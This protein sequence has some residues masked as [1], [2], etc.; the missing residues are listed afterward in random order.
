MTSVGLNGLLLEAP[1]SGTATYTRNLVP[2][3]AQAA[4]ELTFRLYS[5]G[6]ASPP[7]DVQGVRVPWPHMTVAGS[8][9][10]RL[11]KLSWEELALPA[12]SAMKGDTLLHSLYF[13]APFVSRGRLVVTVHDLVPLLMPGYHR[14]RQ[15]AVYARFM[16]G[17]VRRADAIVT[18]SEHSK[19]EIV[20]Q[21][22]IPEDRVHVT[23]EAADSRFR[24]QREPAEEERLR[25]RYSLPERFFLYLG[26]AERRKDI[27]TLVRAWSRIS[28]LMQT[29]GTSLVIVARFP[30]PDTLYP[31]IPG[32]IEA[33]GVAN[34]VLVRAVDESDKPALFRMATAFAFPSVYE[35][36]GLPPLEAMASGV[37]VLASNATSIP[38]VVGDAAVLIPPGE[39]DSWAEALGS[40]AESEALRESLSARGLE[41]AS[42]FSW[43]Q[44]AE[45]TV[46]VY[47]EV[48]GR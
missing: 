45:G 10:A 31:D 16:A 1:L 11:S 23:Y 20:R 26:G 4:P 41:R 9:G 40:V 24:P 27:E 8:T 36:F 2:L 13:A 38:E 39:V 28:G 5:R 15:S 44:T 29:L 30:V 12:M 32:L 6:S 43:T 25:R 17:A 42:R 18:V 19:D 48:L 47:R 34:V 3:L 21:L 7:G 37:P 14:S 33:L 46:A 35:G 22:R